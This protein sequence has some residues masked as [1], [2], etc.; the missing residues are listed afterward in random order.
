M[1]RWQQFWDPESDQHY[2]FDPATGKT[3]WREPKDGYNPAVCF[4]DDNMI[5]VMVGVIKMQAVAR[6]ELIPIQFVAFDWTA[7]AL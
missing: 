3:T 1:A 2:Y 6:Y 7:D 5:D 4:V